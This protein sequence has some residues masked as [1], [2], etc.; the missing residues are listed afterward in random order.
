MIIQTLPV[1]PADDEP[2]QMFIS[3]TMAMMLVTMF[4]PLIHFVIINHSLSC[5]HGRYTHTI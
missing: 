2:K 5:H 3:L 4:A 1:P